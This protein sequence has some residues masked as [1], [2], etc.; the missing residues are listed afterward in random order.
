MSPECGAGRPRGTTGRAVTRARSNRHVGCGAREAIER[1]VGSI[2]MRGSLKLARGMRDA[3]RLSPLSRARALLG[4][5][6]RAVCVLGCAAGGCLCG[7]SRG[8]GGGVGGRRAR[9]TARAGRR[10]RARVARRVRPLRRRPDGQRAPRNA[11]GGQVSRLA[12]GAQ[13]PCRPRRKCSARTT[14]SAPRRGAAGGAGGG[15]C[16]GGRSRGARG[17]RCGAVGIGVAG[18]WTVL[19]HSLDRF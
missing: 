7:H 15:G 6:R 10:L 17:R 18:V 12:A 9:L 19:R 14:T 5:S 3:A 1:R 13:R 2:A 4:R 11:A 8:A 16:A